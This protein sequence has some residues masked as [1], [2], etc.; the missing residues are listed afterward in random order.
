MTFPYTSSKS[1]ENLIKYLGYMSQCLALFAMQNKTLLLKVLLE[2]KVLN[3]FVLEEISVTE[4]DAIWDNKLLKLLYT[5]DMEPG[6]DGAWAF[7]PDKT[8]SIVGPYSEGVDDIARDKDAGSSK[9]CVTMDGDLP[10]GHRE[11]EDFDH[12]QQ[13]G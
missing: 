11:G 2:S 9:A 7:S 12:V 4:Y 13:V 6:L 8:D 10:L 3:L 5:K 1:L